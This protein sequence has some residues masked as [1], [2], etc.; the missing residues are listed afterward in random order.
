MILK[1]ESGRSVCS[2]SS[3]EKLL[4]KSRS[5]E[6]KS[7]QTLDCLLLSRR[8]LNTL[9]SF[10]LGAIKVFFLNTS[11]AMI[12][13]INRLHRQIESIAF[14]IVEGLQDGEMGM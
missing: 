6:M 14:G 12:V 10:S 13:D 4:M 5:V 3:G 8:I 9:G 1:D 2:C 11:F 7:H